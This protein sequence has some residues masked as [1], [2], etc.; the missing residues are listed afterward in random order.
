MCFKKKTMLDVVKEC[1]KINQILKDET[2]CFTGHRSQKLPWGYNE[3]DER[4]IQMRETAREKIEFAISNGYKNFISGMA[5]GF[6]MISAELVLELKKTYPHIKLICA[7]PCKNQ[8]KKW[9]DKQRQRYKNI[10]KQADIVRYVSEEYT[11]TCMLERNN[12]MLNNSSL[13]IALYNGKGGGTGYTIKKA[14]TMNLQTMIIN[15]LTF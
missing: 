6:D 1:E 10:L 3:S 2:V 7:L 9:S 5:L 4:C 14:K 13:V 8:Y 12:Y 11:D 15:P